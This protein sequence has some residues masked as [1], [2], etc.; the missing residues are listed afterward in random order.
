MH[1]C[2]ARSPVAIT[3]GTPHFV[4]II[5]AYFLGTPETVGK[6]SLLTLRWEVAPHSD[7]K[8][9]FCAEFAEIARASESKIFQL[10]SNRIFNWLDVSIFGLLTHRTSNAYAA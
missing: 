7:R 8:F 9:K 10:G 6:P 1:R 3:A 2:N 5:D 4:A